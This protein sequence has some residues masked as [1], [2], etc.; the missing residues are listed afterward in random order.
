MNIGTK[1]DE[2]NHIR[3]NSLGIAKRHCAIVHEKGD[4]VFIVPKNESRV[5]VN[6]QLVEERREIK[7]LDRIVLGHANTFKLV[8][9]GQKGAEDLRGTVTQGGKYGEYLDD[10]LNVP[11]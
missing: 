11:T 4:K 10:R 8:I 5:F 7:H 3:L 6:G 1:E 2:E 9:P